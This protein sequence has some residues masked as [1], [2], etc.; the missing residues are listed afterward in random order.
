MPSL[1]TATCWPLRLKMIASAGTTK[2]GVLRGILEL[3]HAVDPGPQCAVRIWKV[4]LGQERASAAL[5]RLGNPGYRT[6][7]LAIGEFGHADDRGNAGRYAEG[8]V[9]RH[10]DPDADHF[11][12][13]DLEHEGAA[14]RVRLHI[15]ADIDIALRDDAIERSDHGLVVFLLMK[16]PSCLLRYD[17]RLATF[18]AASLLAGSGDRCRPVAR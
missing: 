17:V 1:T 16:P 14:G 7:K 6:G 10:V 9:L 8:R 5:L 15:N 4:D 11:L 2:D 3:D 12:L 18:S 13:H